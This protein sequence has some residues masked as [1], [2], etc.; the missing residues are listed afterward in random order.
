MTVLR[1]TLVVAVCVA[2]S[3]LCPNEA[4]ACSYSRCAH[5]VAPAAG[6]TGVPLETGVVIAGESERTGLQSSCRTC[7]P[8]LES[9]AHRA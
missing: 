5:F 8:H 6:S 7:L 3:L 2:C 4:R 9:E 1:L